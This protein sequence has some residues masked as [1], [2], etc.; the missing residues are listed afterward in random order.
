MS[1]CVN[2]EKLSNDA[3]NNTAIASAGGKKNTRVQMRLKFVRV[4]AAAVKDHSLN[5]PHVTPDTRAALV[6]L[7]FS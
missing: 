7:A 6:K 2:R 3:E 4:A 1:Y 5:I